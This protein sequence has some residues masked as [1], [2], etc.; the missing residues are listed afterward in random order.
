MT[1]ELTYDE[2]VARHER[3]GTTPE[4]AMKLWFDA[5]FLYMDPAT[6]AVGQQA[7]AYLTI[8]LKADAAQWPRRPANGTFRERLEAERHH[9]IFR[10]YARG[11][12]P[13]NGYAMTPEDYAL[14]VVIS[15]RDPYERGWALHLRSSG[16]D[17]PRPV[18]LKQSTKTGLW[19][20]DAFNNT[21]VGVRAP[22]DP[23]VEEFV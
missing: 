7:L 20:V 14:D 17:N 1:Y 21:Y 23:D 4:G 5:V 16:A 11:T 8:P 12:S 18:Y 13:E 15:Q 9:H 6:R 10:S 3:E 2:I 19:F 22:K